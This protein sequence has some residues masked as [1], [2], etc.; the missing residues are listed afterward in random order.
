MSTRSWL[1]RIED[2]ADAIDEIGSF[3][4][5]LSRDQFCADLRTISAFSYQFVI[6]GEAARHIPEEGQIQHPAVPWAKMRAM[7]NVIA[8]EYERVDCT[9]LWETAGSGLPSLFPLLRRLLEPDP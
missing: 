7:R 1:E 6:I 2:I 4:A 3:V 5:G 9:I 8:H